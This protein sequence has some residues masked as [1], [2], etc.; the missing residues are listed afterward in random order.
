MLFKIK[1]YDIE[2]KPITAS[3]DRKAQRFRNKIIESLRKVGIHQ[4]YVEV[5]KERVAIKK[6]KATVSWWTETDHCFYSFDRAG[7]YVD[8]LQVISRLI[9]LETDAVFHKHKTFNEF[10]AA[11]VEDKEVVKQ[12]EEARTL[13]GVDKDCKD[14]SEI[15]NKYKEL[16]RKY[17]PDMPTGDVEKF[18]EINKAHKLL[19]KELE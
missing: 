6:V 19:K 5:S 15:N 18:K 11:F 4:D 2:I 9:E 8:N 17:H 7:R 1:G 12:R 14:M 10:A 16:S 3:F 13:L